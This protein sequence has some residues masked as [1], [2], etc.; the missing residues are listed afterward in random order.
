[1]HY[2]PILSTLVTFAFAVAV[3]SRYRYKKGPHLLFWGIGLIFYGL[4]TLSEVILGFT[5]SA[6]VLKIWYLSGAMLT[7][8]W[9]GQGTIFL[10]VRRRGVATGLAVVLAFISLVSIGLLLASPV[11][12]AAA[13]YNLNQPVSAQYKEILVRNG[14]IIAL[15][16]M[17]NIYGTLGLVGGAL[18]STYLFLRKH[19]LANRMWGNILIAAGALM[20]AMAGSFIKAGLA[21]WLY[22]SELVGVVLMYIGFLRATASP[23]TEQKTV[24]SANVPPAHTSP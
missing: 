11:G 16:I 13:A 15:T 1:M 24:A 19:V 23:V 22:V 18:Y 21:D 5:F 12:A 6:L 7:A 10:L 3:L 8:A 20:P 4:G 9:L 17:L 2:I 14:G